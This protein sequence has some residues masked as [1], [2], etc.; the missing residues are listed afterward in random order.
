MSHVLRVDFLIFVDLFHMICQKSRPQ[1][2]ITINNSHTFLLN[3]VKYAKC[4]T[5]IIYRDFVFIQSQIS[6][7][8]LRKVDFLVLL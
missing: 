4:F 8:V 7:P 6:D 2:Q 3:G 1:L 5:P